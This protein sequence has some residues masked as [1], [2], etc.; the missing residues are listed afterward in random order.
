MN[1]NLPASLTDPENYSYR[2]REWAAPAVSEGDVIMFDE[3]GR[4]LN[5]VCYRAYHFRVVKPEFGPYTLLVKHGGGT[6]SW[7]MEY[8]TRVID[9]LQ[10]LDSDSR[11]L[12]L[13]TIMRAHHESARITAEKLNASWQRAAAQKRIKTRKVKGGVKVWIEP[14]VVETPQTNS[15]ASVV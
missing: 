1:S 13:H 10:S 14:E 4:V 7:R 8:T 2:E 12:L 3:P 6:E 15:L 9:A 11:F 5:N